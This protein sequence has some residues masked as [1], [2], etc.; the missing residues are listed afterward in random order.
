MGKFLGSIVKFIP[1]LTKSVWFTELKSV[2]QL[3]PDFDTVNYRMEVGGKH[4]SC[5]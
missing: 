4:E 1:M 2:M 5:R 3:K